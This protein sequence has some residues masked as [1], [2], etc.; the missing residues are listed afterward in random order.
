[1][2]EV[3]S[4]G[5][6]K[7][8]TE[9]EGTPS[10]SRTYSMKCLKHYTLSG[11]CSGGGQILLATNV[12]HR[13]VEQHNREVDEMD[14]LL[15]EELKLARANQQLKVMTCGVGGA[16]VNVDWCRMPATPPNSPVTTLV[17]WQRGRR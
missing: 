6:P 14:T 15:Q 7:G 11:R 16:N 3:G 5:V 8:E 13:V 10:L 2:I 17:Y 1:M 9:P 12:P 4:R